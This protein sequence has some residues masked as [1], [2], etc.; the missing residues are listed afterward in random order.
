M[1]KRLF[2]LID[3]LLAIIVKIYNFLYFDCYQDYYSKL[4]REE[5]IY[6]SGHIIA[7]LRRHY[8]EVK[9]FKE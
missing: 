8:E 3:K 7:D 5:V 2:A 4:S 9:H 1:E 6:L